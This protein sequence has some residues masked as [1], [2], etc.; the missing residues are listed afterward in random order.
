MEIVLFV[1]FFCLGPLV[2][3]AFGFWLGRGAP[4]FPVKLV[5]R[6][7]PIAY[8]EDEDHPVYQAKGYSNVR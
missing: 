6:D 3:M 1:G 2:L 8:Y 5:R 7:Q 4:G